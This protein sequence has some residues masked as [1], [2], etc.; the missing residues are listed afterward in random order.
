MVDGTA[1]RRVLV[2]TGGDERPSVVAD[3]LGRF[4]L[5]I[6]ADSG[7]HHAQALGLRVNLVVGDFDSVTDAAVERAVAQGAALERFPAAKDQTDL[8]L[9]MDRA[10]ELGG[11]GAEL[12]VVAGVGG[13]LDHALANMLLLSSPAYAHVRVDA[14]VDR[15][16]VSV[17]RD[18]ARTFAA[19]PGRT[20]TL[21]VVHPERAR[22]ETEGL[23]YPLRNELVHRSSTRGVSNVTLGDEFTV[24]VQGGVLL[25]LREWAD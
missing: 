20:V 11:I 19:P 8:E 23:A 3:R 1:G 14:C 22:V 7:L 21:L 25:V 13:R 6:A 18:E 5:V 15:W 12:V 17:L 16:W 2:V 4:D 10:T 9:A 24:R